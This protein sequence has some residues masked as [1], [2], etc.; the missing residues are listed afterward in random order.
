ML[1]LATSPCH[2]DQARTR[3]TA[4]R[5]AAVCYSRFPRSHALGHLRLSTPC[6]QGYLGPLGPRVHVAL[7]L[8]LQSRQ[9]LITGTPWV[10]W[11]TVPKI[12]PTH[13][14]GY[15]GR[16]LDPGPTDRSCPRPG[17]WALTVYS[18]L[19]HS[20][21]PDHPYGLERIPE[22]W[23]PVLIISTWDV[24]WTLATIGRLTALCKDSPILELTS[25]Y[26]SNV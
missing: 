21:S 15:L 3:S 20:S 2:G 19:H 8:G 5:A 13:T 22:T 11:S 24:F 12:H 4:G 7:N 10:P 16:F 14:P 9:K 23:T 26:H 18:T 25:S 6:R 17:P 1:T